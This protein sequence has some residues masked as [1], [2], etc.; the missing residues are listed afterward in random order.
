[1]EAFLA[2]QAQGAE[3]WTYSCGAS[4]GNDG[5]TQHC[6]DSGVSDP[7][8][9]RRIYPWFC[10][11]WDFKGFLLFTMNSWG[12]WTEE[13]KNLTTDPA[14][15]WPLNG[16]KN[17]TDSDYQLIYPAPDGRPVASMRLENL[18]DGMEDYEYLYML[19]DLLAKLKAAGIAP[20][21][22]KQGEALLN[23]EPDI[24]VHANDFVKDPSLLVA[25]RNAIGDLIVKLRSE[26]QLS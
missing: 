8:L 24:I 1:R 22:V 20:E 21:L 11:K 15:R 14:K 18:R 5:E 19:E 4:Y 16:E 2:E 9:E 13:G 3:F 26:L 25:R 10:Y 6:P 12:T 23:L 7:P 17:V